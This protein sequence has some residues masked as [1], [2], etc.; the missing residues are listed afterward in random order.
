MSDFGTRMK[1][2][3]ISEI[4]ATFPDTPKRLAVWAETDKY[5]WKEDESVWKQ[6]RELTAP[7]YEAHFDNEFVCFLDSSKGERYC[8]FTFLSGINELYKAE[9]IFVHVGIY[10]IKEAERKAKADNDVLEVPKAK[11]EAED[12]IVKVIKKQA[13]KKK[14][15]V[16]EK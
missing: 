15:K 11:N 10:E 4:G 16:V 8:L 6:K 3:I 2:L 5:K 7:Q 9:K 14:R 12:M 13:K 1:E